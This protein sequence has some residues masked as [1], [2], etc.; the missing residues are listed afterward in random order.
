MIGS[1]ALSHNFSEDA[2]KSSHEKLVDET[3]ADVKLEV[4]W[5][6]VKIK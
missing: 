3:E 2:E 1:D 4:G 6:P 5:F